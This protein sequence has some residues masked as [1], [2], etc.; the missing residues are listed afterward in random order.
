[1]NTNIVIDPEIRFGKPTLKG[2]RITV[3]DVLGWLAGGMDFDEIKEEYGIDKKQVTDALKY[4]EG[5]VKG[6][7]VQH[8]EVSVGR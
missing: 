5:W 7:S 6:E 3:T 4:M 8:Y 2:T 1:M